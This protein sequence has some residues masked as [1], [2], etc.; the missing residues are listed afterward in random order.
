MLPISAGA[1]PSSCPFPCLP[2]LP[3]QGLLSA[4]SLRGR[5]TALTPGSRSPRREGRTQG[6]RL[7]L[8][9]SVPTRAGAAAALRPGHQRGSASAGEARASAVVPRGQR[10]PRC[11]PPVSPQTAPPARSW[12][13]PSGF[14]E[15]RELAAPTEGYMCADTAPPSTRHISP[16]VN[17]SALP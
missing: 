14:G 12:R 10:A 16:L 17:G 4:L 13:I 8:R 5:G 1:P 3:A 9:G 7:T 2:T 11:P 15:L 6:Q